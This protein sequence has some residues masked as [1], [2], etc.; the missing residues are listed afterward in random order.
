MLGVPNPVLEV[1]KPELGAAGVPNP[2]P[3]VAAWVPKL[4]PLPNGDAAGPDKAAEEPKPSPP[5]LSAVE[6]EDWPKGLA[7]DEED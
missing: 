5:K 4:S 2:A 3:G 1:P 7:A 6:E